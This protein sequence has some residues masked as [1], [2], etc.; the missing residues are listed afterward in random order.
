MKAYIEK[1]KEWIQPILVQ[2]QLFLVDVKGSGNKIEVF[3]DGMQNVTIDQCAAISR[4]LDEFI[5]AE[6]PQQKQ[7]FLE[8][9]SPGMFSPIKVIQQYQKRMGRDLDVV[10]ND[11]EKITGKLAGMNETGIIL[12]V[13]E[14]DKK[15]KTEE[16][17][18]EEIPFDDIKK[19][20]VNFKF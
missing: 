15:K 13:V 6:T 5:D 14:K 19:A 17:K 2:E 20:T 3:V 10:R 16:I 4:F 8:V 12:E 1:I 18:Q 11:G 7:F 9:S